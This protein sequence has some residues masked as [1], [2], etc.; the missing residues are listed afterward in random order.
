M[1]KEFDLVVVGAD[2]Y[3]YVG[4]VETL[5]AFKESPSDLLSCLCMS[6]TVL[7]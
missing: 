5:V 2:Y 4:I 3:L 6:P 1:T 7:V